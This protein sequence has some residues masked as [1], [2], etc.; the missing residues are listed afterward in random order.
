MALASEQ[1]IGKVECNRNWTANRH[2]ETFRARADKVSDSECNSDTEEQH[3]HASDVENDH[4]APHRAKASTGS[5]VWATRSRAKSVVNV[6][7]SSSPPWWPRADRRR[8]RRHH[9]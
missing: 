3:D 6:A 7:T 4:T 2:R 8:T 5:S 9:F 1:T